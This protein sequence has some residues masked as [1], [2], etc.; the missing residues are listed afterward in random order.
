ML[1]Y[2]NEK[3]HHFLDAVVW[4]T[5]WAI[6]VWLVAKAAL[7]F[8][9]KRLSDDARKGLPPFVRYVAGVVWWA[10]FFGLYL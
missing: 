10:V 1:Y 5:V 3:L 7:P 6:L 9:G 2:S 4:A 8:L